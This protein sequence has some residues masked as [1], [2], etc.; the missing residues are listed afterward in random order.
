MKY[1]VQDL[2]GFKSVYKIPTEK[3]DKLTVE[4]REKLVDII[5]G[6]AVD[7]SGNGREVKIIETKKTTLFFI[8]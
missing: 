3:W 6:K 8:K 7:E 1:N 2:R 4:Q 5:I